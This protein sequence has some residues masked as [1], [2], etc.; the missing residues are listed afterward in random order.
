MRLSAKTETVRLGDVEASHDDWL[1]T[2]CRRVSMLEG[3]GRC[4]REGKGKERER[5][6]GG[7][8]E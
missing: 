2:L 8:G 1:K 5:K 3:S 6:K 7:G 4:R